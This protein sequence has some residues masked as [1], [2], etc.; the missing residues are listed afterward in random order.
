MGI[1]PTPII[2]DTSARGQED[3]PIPLT[4]PTLHEQEWR[5]LKECLETGW[6]SSVGP[7][8][9]RFE[10][11][12]AGRLGAAYGVATVNGT[13]ALH[14]A[15]LVAG[16]QP[17][18]IVLVSS[19][20][21]IAPANAIRYVGAWPLFIDAERRYWQMDPQRAQDVLERACRWRRGA[22]YH[23]RTGRRVRAILPVHLL[24]HPCDMEPL[25]AQARK[26]GLVVIED[27]AESL[28]ARYQD[29]MV[30]HLGDLGCLSFNGN[31]TVT[32]GGGGMILTDQAAWAERAR[33]LTTQAK[34]DPIESSHHEVG[35]NYRLSNLHAALGCAQVERLDESLA[36]KRQIARRYAQAL[37]STPGLTVP[38]EAPWAFSAW[39]MT[40]VL[41]NEA[42]SGM[43]SRAL[44]RRLQTLGIET[45]P[46]WQPLHR[47]PAHR[48]GVSMDCPVAEDL[49][50][51]ALCLPSSVGLTDSQQARV[52]EALQRMRP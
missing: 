8:V 48:R 43:D 32:A 35:Y 49:A 10:Q 36:A 13:A 1:A 21:F 16:V 4:A 27:A 23:T 38:S 19:L 2:S 37:A 20:S 7:F 50:R 47:S 14:I 29:Q 18:E 46:L 3:G 5:Y 30:G 6:V 52:I 41:V 17:D 31:K 34:D 45:R 42:V 12:V 9:D 33:Y 22:L 44:H 24:G 11:M 28:G 40:T 15:L 39:W 26:Y 25:L 51:K